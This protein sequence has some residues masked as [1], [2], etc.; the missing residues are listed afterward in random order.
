MYQCLTDNGLLWCVVLAVCLFAL[1]A[2]ICMAVM[3][4]QSL[5][6]DLSHRVIDK[7]CGG[8]NAN[9]SDKLTCDVILIAC[10]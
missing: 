10:G 6:D 1:S 2:D 7:P 9:R 4:V 8:V 3:T 5:T